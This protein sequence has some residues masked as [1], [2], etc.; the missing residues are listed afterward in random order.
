METDRLPPHSPEAEL[1][2][3]S[4]C[5]IESSCIDACLDRLKDGV[6]SFYELRNQTLYGVIEQMHRAREKVD[7]VTLTQKLQD[8]G[9]LEDAG[10]REYLS[11]LFSVV[12]THYNLPSY[13][14]IVQSKYIN[15]RLMA[16]TTL[17]SQRAY[18]ES[19]TG[20]LVSLIE[21]ELLKISELTEPVTLHNTTTMAT[22]LVDDLEFRFN[23]KGKLTGVE[24]GFHHLDQMTWGLQYGEQ[25][26]IG[27]RPSQGKTAIAVN[28]VDHACL[29]NQVP[30]LFITCEM[31]PAAISRRLMACHCGISMTD[32][33]RGEFNERD[34]QEFTHFNE[35]YKRA[36]L[37]ILDAVSG[38]NSDEINSEVRR[39]VR[40][41]G[42][43]LVVLDY[44][45]KVSS[46]HRQE[47]RTYEVGAVSGAL[48]SCAIKNNVAFLVLAQLNRE[49]ERDKGRPPRLSDLADSGQIERDGD[50]I[51]LLHRRKTKE[52]IQPMLIVA[53]QRDGEIGNVLLDWNGRCCRFENWTAPEQTGDREI[54]SPHN[55]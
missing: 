29:V 39:H 35:L 16:V 36:P 9:K 17:V 4:C 26:I 18:S 14:D 11:T 3:I 21:S 23:N 19:G 51:G 28:I 50:L 44:L 33:R 32:I 15:R 42:T 12:D 7:T 6:K 20:E 27:A 46:V 10:G 25:S 30:T 5:L 38:I 22:R 1:A 43:K 45:Q 8:T 52:S 49:S 2:V 41:N 34:F 40:V 31:S 47:K 37:N 55:D 53:K 54:K 24:T 13:L 48:K